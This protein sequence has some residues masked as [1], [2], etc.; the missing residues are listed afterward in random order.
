MFTNAYKPIISGVVTSVTIFRQAL[1]ERGHQVYIFAP[2]ADNYEDTEPYIF[3][4]FAIDLT[5]RFNIAVTFPVTRWILPTLR[6]LKPDLIHSQHPILMGD[7]AAHCAE[8]MNLP[9]VFTFHTKYDVQ[10]QRWV[11]V[12]GDLLGMATRE[13][14]QRYLD[15]CTHIIAPTNSIRRMIYQDYEVEVPVTVVP[16]PI[17]LS[18]YFTLHPERIRAKYGLMD[19]EVLLYV[20]RIAPEK[21]LD[22]LL[23]SFAHI[24]EQRPRARLLLVGKGPHLSEFQKQARKLGIAERV[25]FA[26]G[27]PHE[28]IPDHMAAGDLFVFPSTFETQGLVLIEAL[29]AGTPVVAVRAT[30]SSDVLADGKGG[31]LVELDED[32]FAEAVLALLADDERRQRMRLEAKEVAQGYSIAGAT[33]RLERAYQ[34]ALEDGPKVSRRQ[35]S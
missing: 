23:R 32:D 8:G 18:K 7:C 3:R 12:V 28:E 19:A 14:V 22:L 26:G 4:Y 16:T 20:G 11:P 13:S 15:R 5:D 35:R 33:D 6:G 29:A 17:D 10:V 27:V 34:R 21:N 24:A 25:I 9:L 30:G 1:I 31:I 2:E